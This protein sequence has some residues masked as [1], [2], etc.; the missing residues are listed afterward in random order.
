[1]ERIVSP[2][3]AGRQPEEIL[4]RRWTAPEPRA[5]LLLVHGLGGHSDR[6][7]ECARRWAARGIT[8]YAPDLQGFG[9]TAGP[10]G[11]IDSFQRY[12]RDLEKLL[13]RA[14]AENSR[15]PLFLLGE[16]MGAVLAVDFV[17]TRPAL[18]SGLV[19]VAPSLADRLDVPAAR[20]A[21]AFIH[22]LFRHRKWYD[23]P[24]NPRAFTRDE[25][26]IKFLENDPLEVRRVTAQF[27]FAYAA[28]VAR[29]RREASFL[30]LPV[31]LLLPGEDRMIDTDYSRAW[32]ERVPSPDKRLIEYPGFFHAL[33]VEKDRQV[34][35]EE[36]GEWIVTRA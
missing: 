11:H 27:Y 22:L 29:A 25:A 24:W 33:L 28:V 5:A 7:Q 23:L 36:I 20:K 19:L 9:H 17:A 16:S 18:L 35:H 21:E 32:F 30:H 34:V 31:L 1:M 3:P 10:R 15:R 26:F 12:H 6:F 13:A 14:V 2:G 8:T 4:F